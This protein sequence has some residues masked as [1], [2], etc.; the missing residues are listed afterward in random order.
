MIGNM[1][2]LLTLLLVFSLVEPATACELRPRKRNTATTIDFCLRALDGTAKTNAT[3]SSGDVKVNVDEAGEANIGTLPTDRG[4]CYSL[5]LTAAEVGGARTYVTIINNAAYY[6]KCLV[7]ETYG[8]STATNN[9]PD[10]NLTKVDGTATNAVAKQTA[11]CNANTPALLCMW[12]IGYQLMVDR[13]VSENSSSSEATQT[14][15][16]PDDTTPVGS[17][18]FTNDGTTQDRGRLE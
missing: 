13:L 2:L 8:D 5:P 1:K 14:L 15:Y 10:V 9:I 4:N 7:I 16:G 6:P 17:G 11:I 12:Q 3:F 18:T